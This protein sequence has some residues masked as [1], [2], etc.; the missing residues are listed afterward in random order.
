M[1]SKSQSQSHKNPSLSNKKSADKTVRP[2]L[3]WPVETLEI[4]RDQ[5]GNRANLKD[6]AEARHQEHLRRQAEHKLSGVV[7]GHP[8]I[9]ES[10]HIDPLSDG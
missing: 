3:S 9:I 10:T 1:S 7:E 5:P 6:T 2:I 4:K 8:G